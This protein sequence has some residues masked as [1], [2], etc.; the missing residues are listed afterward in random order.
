M[1]HPYLQHIYAD[2][3]DQGSFT[4]GVRA[5][6]GRPLLA[7]ML[8]IGHIETL[9]SLLLND[10]TSGNNLI[11][12]MFTPYS[13]SLTQHDSSE[14]ALRESPTSLIPRMVKAG[15]RAGTAIAC[16]CATATSHKSL[17]LLSQL[18]D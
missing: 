18:L 2:V 7:T 4:K 17:S 12:S 11:Y 5:P 3:A 8:G 9:A 13:A 15:S 16:A 10:R 1:V 6:R 14:T